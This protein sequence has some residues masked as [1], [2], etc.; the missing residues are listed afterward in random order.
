[1]GRRLRMEN[2]EVVE[3]EDI[4]LAPLVML[5][6]T[7]CGGYTSFTQTSSTVVVCDECGTEQ[8]NERIVDLNEERK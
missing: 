6:C 2:G 4:F 7:E 5:D 8:S 1:M 3:E